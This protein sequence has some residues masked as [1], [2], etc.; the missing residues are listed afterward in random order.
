MT[1]LVALR[2]E[3]YVFIKKKSSYNVFVQYGLRMTNSDD[4]CGVVLSNT[5]L[6]DRELT[7]QG[8]FSMCFRHG[9]T[10]KLTKS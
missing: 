9:V 7:E 6:N 3:R 10:F 4:F 1:F 5:R 8:Q 2:F